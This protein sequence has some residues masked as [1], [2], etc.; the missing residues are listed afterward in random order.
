M[1]NITCPHCHQTFDMDNADYGDIL[2]QVRNKEFKKEIDAKMNAI[3][4]NEKLQLDKIKLET[5]QKNSE[6]LA[7]RDKE[8]DELKH[9]LDKI[10]LE[11]QSSIKDALYN[12]QKEKAELETKLSQEQ[13][14]KALSDKTLKENFDTQI[15]LQKENFANQL[16]DREE[17][18]QRLQ[19]LKTRLST[20]MVGET[21]EQHCEV[22]FNKIRSAAFPLAEFH[23]DNDAR[24]GSKGDFIFRD[25]TNEGQEIISIMFEMKNESDM[26]ATK[27]K[28]EDFF[29][30]LDKD[31][32]EKNCEYAVLVSLLESDNDFYNTGIVDVSYRYEKMYV[33][34]PQFFIPMITLLRNA[35]L[36][37][38]EYKTQ[39]QIVQQNNTDVTNFEEKLEKFKTAFARNYDIASR[40]FEKVINEIDQSIKHL[41]KIKDSLLGTNN[42]LRLA[43][44]KAQDVTIRKLTYKNP[45]MQKKF[46]QKNNHE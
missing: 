30:E 12:A 21:L 29:K 2:N 38:V 11:H 31:R 20:K 34:R 36:N 40:H 26:T 43:N 17:T 42:N 3:K 14:A 4:Q 8:I 1:P 33:I 5:Q 7:K 10:H 22:E 25:H 6:D 37:S 24:T 35:A 28:N 16:K 46:A 15:R 44:D 18:I 19:D 9:K 13:Y 27:K 41:Q 39:L 32:R 45:T 23:K